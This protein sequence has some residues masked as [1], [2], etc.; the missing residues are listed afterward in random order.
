MASGASRS[1]RRRGS[2]PR[3]HRR[4]RWARIDRAPQDKRDAEDTMLLFTEDK[5]RTTA[6]AIFRGAG[7]DPEPTAILVDHLIGANLAGHDSHGVLRIPHYVRAIAKGQIQPNARPSIV[8][9][10]G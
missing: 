8:K 5:L 9:E 3:C 4:R 1:R 6:T 2:G 7:A 10:T